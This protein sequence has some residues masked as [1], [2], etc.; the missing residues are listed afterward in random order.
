M[1]ACYLYSLLMVNKNG[2]AEV[3]IQPDQLGEE[4]LRCLDKHNTED[5]KRCERVN[6]AVRVGESKR[7]TVVKASDQRADDNAVSCS[8]H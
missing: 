5:G 8:A 6:K 1:K 3:E 2:Q 4:C 7:M